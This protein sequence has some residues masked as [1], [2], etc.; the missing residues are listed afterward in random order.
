MSNQL[1]TILRFVANYYHVTPSAILSP[2][3]HA[4]VARPRQM[5][6]WLMHCFNPSWGCL[7]DID[8]QLGRKDGFT[9]YCVRTVEDFMSV[10][11]YLRRQ[12][13]ELYAALHAEFFPGKPVQLFV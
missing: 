11:P 9:G 5:A 13:L 7:R 12:A 1:N 2:L 10:E 6:A 4:N 8:R 3:Q